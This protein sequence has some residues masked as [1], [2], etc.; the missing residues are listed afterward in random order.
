MEFAQ[1]RTV[2]L[3]ERMRPYADQVL[4]GLWPGCWV[5]RLKGVVNGQPH[6]LD[7][8]FGIDALVHLRSGQWISMQEKY[9]EYRCLVDPGLQI[10]PPEP[11]FTQEYMNAVGTDRESPGEWFHLAAQVYFF[12]WANEDETAFAKW[13]LLNVPRYKLIVESAGGIERFGKLRH[14][15]KHGKASF[16]CFPISKVKSAW[17]AMHW[18][19]C[20]EPSDPLRL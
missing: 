16:Y 4:Q 20:V 19:I 17:I 7:R 1:L 2:D 13:V 14:N 6:V 8:E 18:G 5:E 12:G 10:R 11:D 15:K 9:R 3:Y